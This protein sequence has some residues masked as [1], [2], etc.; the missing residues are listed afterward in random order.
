MP[1]GAPN[2][3]LPFR[4]TEHPIGPGTQ[5]ETEAQVRSVL[6]AALQTP[7]I[8]FTA[9]GAIGTRDSHLYGMNGA[10][11][12][13]LTIEAPIPGGP[14]IGD[15]GKTLEFISMNTQTNVITGPINSIN[16]SKQTATAIG[17]APAIS[18]VQ[19]INP[20]MGSQGGNPTAVETFASPN[21]LGNTLVAVG[22]LTTSA[23]PPVITDS[24][25]NP[26]PSTPVATQPISGGSMG[27]PSIWVMILTNCKAGANTVT[28]GTGPTIGDCAVFEIAGVDTVD[29]VSTL[30][31]NANVS[32]IFTGPSVTT[33]AAKEALIAV[34]GA[35]V[36][37]P[38]TNPVVNAP[39]SD[40][41]E[42]PVAP[43]NVPYCCAG[44]RIVSAIGTYSAAATMTA[45]E[46]GC[47]AILLGMYTPTSGG[48]GSYLALK[49]LS[50]IW[51]VVSNNGFTLS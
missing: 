42:T 30:L 38:S 21:T 47:G 12:I 23:L 50:G 15:D 24:L 19:Y 28:I 1:N 29:Q 33:T 18:L 34:F 40:L 14:G 46:V 35:G 6:A 49:A 3:A 2:Y 13:T 4:L 26:W 11:A 39:F 27:S 31:G 9:S 5:S 51:Y 8:T 36:G 32:G 7:S 17:E 44:I 16:G 43:L 45:S 25:G 22:F 10:G 20:V 37:L 41:T 48:P